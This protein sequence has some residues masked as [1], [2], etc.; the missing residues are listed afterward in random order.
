MKCSEI[1]AVLERLAPPSC[2]CDWDNVGL[3]VGRYDKEVKKIRIALDAND[4][5]VEQAAAEGTDML[6]THHPMIFRGVKAVNDGTFLG[7]RILKLAAAD[8]SYYAMHT[9]FDGAPGC[10]ADLAADRLGLR[11]REVLEKLGELDGRPYGIGVV[12]NLEEPMSLREL[13]L[14][15]KEAFGLPFARIYGGDAGRIT[16]VAMCPGSGGSVIDLAK[17][18]GA[19]V[20]ITGDVGYHEGTDS[21]AD[22]M[23]VI[24]GG[25]Y[26]I[27]HLFIGFME[28]YLRRQLGDGVEIIPT[29]VDFP[30][31]LV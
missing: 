16:R 15:V 12:G 2:A 1:I 26:G 23:A 30:A 31:S 9:N 18:S 28:G 3:L 22:G 20:Y 29:A 14:L 25:H 21:V 11:D 10:M 24:D 5:V 17:A 19:S 13:A 27:E 6:L 7:R 4:Q 8:I